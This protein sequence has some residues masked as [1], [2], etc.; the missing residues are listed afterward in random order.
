MNKIDFFRKLLKKLWMV[1]QVQHDTFSGFFSFCYP[2]PFG[3]ARPEEQRSHISKV[4]ER[5]QDRFIS[6]SILFERSLTI[7]ILTIVWCFLFFALAHA[8][9][10]HKKIKLQRRTQP[11]AKVNKSTLMLKKTEKIAVHATKEVAQYQ[12]K[13]DVGQKKEFSFYTAFPEF[14]DMDVLGK[15]LIDGAAFSIGVLRAQSSKETI[16]LRHL[17]NNNLIGDD[18]FAKGSEF[19]AQTKCMLGGIGAEFLLQ[20]FAAEKKQDTLYFFPIDQSSVVREKNNTATIFYR[21]PYVR[22]LNILVKHVIKICLKDK[23]A[24]LYESGIAGRSQYDELLKILDAYNVKPVAAARY[25]QGSVEIDRALKSIADASPNVIFCLS[26]PRPTYKFIKQA[27]DAGMHT[28]LFVGPSPLISIQQ[29]LK[30]V[31]GVDLMTVSV[32]PPEKSEIELIKKY[33]EAFAKRFA[34][35]RSNPF[36]LESFLYLNLLAKALKDVPQALEHPELLI[37]Y[38]ER[39]KKVDFWGVPL[40][41]D[42]V[43]RSLAS[44]VWIAPGVDKPWIE[45][46]A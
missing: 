20:R 28:M 3:T 30:T 42:P 8:D 33:K 35:K 40:T 29:L 9:T 17:G 24:I 43:S 19:L 11:Q 4:L 1:K 31:R 25:A 15:Q 34:F 37:Q 23:I 13:I 26:K 21:Q 5:A 2:E 12:K 14:G 32:V 27:V 22:E 16:P 38:F 41:F 10:A 36:Y 6:R 39:F 45:V 18:G 44:K 7:K 46:N